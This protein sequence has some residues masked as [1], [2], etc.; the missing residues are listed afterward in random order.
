MKVPR[1]LSVGV[2]HPTFESWGGAEWFIH[3]LLESW[4]AGNEMNAVLYTYRWSDPP[5]GRADYPVVTHGLGGIVSGPWDWRAIGRFLAP[6]WS[7]HDVLFVHNHPAGE[8][9][10]CSQSRLPFVWYCQEPPRSLWDLQHEVVQPGPTRP[11]DAREVFR[12]L[13]RLG[14][15]RAFWR[16]SSRL[17]LALI[18][19]WIGAE[20]WSD[21]LRIWD[22][23][24]VQAAA[25]I[26]AN[27]HFTAGRVTSIYGR[28]ATVAYP[29]LPHFDAQT[30]VP[31]PDKEPVVLWVGRLA[32]EKRPEMMLQAWQETVMREG[33]QH[34]KL[35]MVGDGPMRPL[36][37]EQLALLI[38]NGYAELRTGVATPELHALYRRALLTVH[39]GR[40]E[41]FGLVPL[42]SLWQGTTVLADC[43]GGVKETVVP[44]QTGYC[45]ED[46]SADTLSSALVRLLLRPEDLVE[47]GQKGALAVRRKFSFETT[48]ELIVR[49][50]SGA[51]RRDR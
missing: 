12:S 21:R 5:G 20:K 36:I 48:V 45:V 29:L 34:F 1:P 10:R 9:V 51:A 19:G 37:E 43:A 8:W 22:R 6:R 44:N 11:R 42:E 23:E 16:V 31:V 15:G 26:I 33:C 4:A 46:P 40:E 27:S 2:L 35:I 39:L 17:R 7:G 28:E 25:A 50:L 13:R 49:T 14:P 30:P 32:P 38:E 18:R 3:G 41:P 24:T 47:M